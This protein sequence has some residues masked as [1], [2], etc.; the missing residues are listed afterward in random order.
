MRLD[1]W[2]VKM[3][4]V[5]SRSKAQELIRLGHV[6][7]LKDQ[8][9]VSECDV[10]WDA[11]RLQREQA[12]IADDSLLKYVSRGGLKLEGAL[13]HCQLSVTGWRCLDVGQ[14]TGGFTDCLLQR[15]AK[16]VWGFDVGHDQLHESLTEDLRVKA[17]S[18]L[19]VKDFAAHSDWQPRL[20]EHFDL[21]VADVSFISLSQVLPHIIRAILAPAKLLLL[22][23]PQFEL[24]AK[25]LDKSGVVKD[26]QKFHSVKDKICHLALE[27]QCKVLDYFPSSPRGQD[28]NQEF[29]LYAEFTDRHFIGERSGMPNS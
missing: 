5:P 28:G 3:Q 22:V 24:E 13:N 19:H 11:S 18:G 10:S 20:K 14:S 21:C 15:G 17:F 4:L 9:W 6:E 12:R 27:N 26:A 8:K 23:K 25:D 16:E 1:Q 2:L 29:F 7:I